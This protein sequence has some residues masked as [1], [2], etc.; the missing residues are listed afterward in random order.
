MLESD[1]WTIE[2]VAYYLERDVRTVRRYVKERKL[3]ME[4]P[5]GRHP[6]FRKEKLDTWVKHNRWVLYKK[7]PNK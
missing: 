1:V 7:A 2:Q 6:F 4:K 5:K 3:P